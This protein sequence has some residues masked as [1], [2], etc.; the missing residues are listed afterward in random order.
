MTVN[1]LIQQLQSLPDNER[2][3]PVALL[4]NDYTI[5]RPLWV[6]FQNIRYDSDEVPADVANLAFPS[7]C[8]G[9]VFV[10]FVLIRK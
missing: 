7:G 6:G 10:P 8:P 5:V 2:E 1:E 4:G 9:E 3:Y